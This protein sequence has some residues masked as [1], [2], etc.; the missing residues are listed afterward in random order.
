MKGREA[1]EA[2]GSFARARFLKKKTPYIVGW[3]V[4]EH[5]NAACSY[6]GLGASASHELDT[7]Q[8][9]R[10]IEEMHASGT[11]RLNVTGGEPLIRKDIGMLI[12]RAAGLGIRVRMNSNGILLPR[13]LPELRNLDT[14][15]LSLDGPV[16]VHDK[17]RG[18]GSFRTT[19]DAAQAALAHDIRVNFTVTLTS[20]NCGSLP[21][22]LD[23]ATAFDAKISFQPVL[24]T[25]LA[26]KEEHGLVPTAEALRRAMEILIEEKRRG[27]REIFQSEQ[28]LGHIAHWPEPKEIRCA[29]GWLSCRVEADGR[30]LLCSRKPGKVSPFHPLVAGFRRAFEALSPGSCVDCWCASRVELNFMLHG[31]SRSLLDRAVTEL[32]RG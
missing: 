11:R 27:R 19:L 18:P 29:C 23:T 25:R 6:C 2:A 16:N 26:T 8:A 31:G 10:L 4:T 12:D 17:I 1:A 24:P 22:L 14:V 21:Y 7:L 20:D 5:C 3:C 32:R 15:N 9:L 30:I 13:K 28:G